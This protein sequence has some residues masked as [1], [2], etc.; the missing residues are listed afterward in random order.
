MWRPKYYR[1]LE[2]IDPTQKINLFESPVTPQRFGVRSLARSRIGFLAIFSGDSNKLILSQ[3][4][5]FEF[6]Y[7]VKSFHYI[8]FHSVK[9]LE[10]LHQI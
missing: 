5:I 3:I 2:N 1:K 9:T 6:C 8:S 10:L 7:A 4:D